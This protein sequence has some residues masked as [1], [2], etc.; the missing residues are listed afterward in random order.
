MVV[1]D[2]LWAPTNPSVAE[3]AISLMKQTCHLSQSFNTLRKRTVSIIFLQLNRRPV[4]HC[5]LVRKIT[6]NNKILKKNTMKDISWKR[7]G[8]SHAFMWN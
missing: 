1:F 4:R 3:R 7:V 2:V 6:Q 8:N 5:K